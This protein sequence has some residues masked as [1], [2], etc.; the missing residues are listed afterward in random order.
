M[1]NNFSIIIAGGV[2]IAIIVLIITLYNNQETE[3]IIIDKPKEI[4]FNFNNSKVPEIS[5]IDE[6]LD[7]IEKNASENIYQP[8]SREWQTS[9][10]FQ[11]DRSKYLIGEKIFLVIGDLGLDEKGQ[12]AFLRPMNITHVAVWQTIPFDGTKKSAFN[13]YTQPVL[14]TALDICTVDDI[15]GDW[16]VVFR[17]T[18]YPDLKF[19]IINKIIP[20]DEESYVPVC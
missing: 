20:G 9:G 13:F 18:D 2:G 10:P 19:K 17:G 1:K 15:I 11:I 8:A 14:N 3:I 6:K 12:I 16:R 7:E 4:E 5:D